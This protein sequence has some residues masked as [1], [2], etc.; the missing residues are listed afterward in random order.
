MIE[1]E[2]PPLKQ[3][4]DHTQVHD[5]ANGKS[6][7]KCKP[8]RDRSPEPVVLGLFRAVLVDAGWLQYRVYTPVTRARIRGLEVVA[9]L[10][11]PP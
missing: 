5:E 7:Y 4:S 9:F 1:I 8:Q 6:Q 11:V 3:R 2:T 10:A